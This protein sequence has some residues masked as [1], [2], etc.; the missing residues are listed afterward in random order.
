MKF[1]VVVQAS[2]GA[3]SLPARGVRIE[4]RMCRAEWVGPRVTPRKG[5]A[6]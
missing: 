1:D 5:S 4:I 6:D 3:A 2:D